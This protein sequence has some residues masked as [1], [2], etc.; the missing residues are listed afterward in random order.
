MARSL[1]I[2]AV[3]VAAGALLAGLAGPSSGQTSPLMR[4]DSPEMNRRAPDKFDVRLET[5]KGPIVLEIVRDWSPH[6]VETK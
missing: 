2:I 3:V 4:P 5:S 1:C 6:G